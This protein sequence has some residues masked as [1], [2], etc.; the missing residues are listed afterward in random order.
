MS[1]PDYTGHE[2]QL[3][4]PARRLHEVTPSDTADLPWPARALTC[5]VE[6]DVRVTSSGG[7]T[8][9]LHMFAGGC[10]AVQVRRV[11]ATGTTAT[12]IVAMA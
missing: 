9:T 10:L 8:A 3:H 12:G 5:L 7:D 1:D 11:W 2:V 4:D 6:G